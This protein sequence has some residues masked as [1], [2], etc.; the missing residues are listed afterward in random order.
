M[1]LLIPR[2]I[3]TQSLTQFRSRL[4][5]PYLSPR[6][7]EDAVRANPW[8]TPYYL[9]TS[10]LGIKKWLNPLRVAAFLAPYSWEQIAPRRVGII[11]AG[12]IPMVGFQD[13]FM[14]LLAGH[15]AVLKCSRQDTVMM[16]WLLEQWVQ[17]LPQL[18]QRIEFTD[19]P[20]EIDYLIATGSDN[21][22]R[23]LDVQYEGVPRTLRG[24]RASVA[25]IDRTLTEEEIHSLS[26]DILLYN[27]LGCRNVSL[28]L[29]TPEANFDEIT[30]LLSRQKSEQINPLYLEKVTRERARLRTLGLNHKDLGMMLLREVNSFNWA[31]MGVL[32]VFFVDSRSEAI[33]IIETNSPQIQCVVN[34]GIEFGESQYPAVDDFADNVN[35]FEILTRI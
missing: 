14:T 28:L 34:D 21:T 5:A 26:Q 29:V 3:L 10:L 23:H 11:A 27:G 25:V 8:F 24:H 9:H 30:Y 13:V 1:P 2:D 20:Q 33:Q 32:N 35:I 6:V 4:A 19:H 15:I 31:P 17:V 18:E 7:L 22:A 16:Q 12:N